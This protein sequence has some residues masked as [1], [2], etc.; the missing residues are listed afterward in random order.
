MN[1]NVQVSLEHT[2]ALQREETNIAREEVSRLMETKRVQKTTVILKTTNLVLVDDIEDENSTLVRAVD[3]L[4][5][6][7]IKTLL[8]NNPTNFTT[9]F[10]LVV[11]P[12]DCPTVADWDP[13]KATTWRYRVIGGNHGAR[14][15]TELYKAYGR[16][17]FNELQAWVYADLTRDEI[18]KLSIQHNIDQEYR[19]KMSNID[20]ARTIHKIFVA[21]GCAKTKETREACAQEVCLD[22]YIP[23]VPKTL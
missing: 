12:E 20:Q 19:K 9:P 23:G 14:A 3:R 22:G 2:T 5:V 11:V 6:E 18:Q 8:K 10:V 21:R 7:N 15:K 1:V 17:I 4:H 13:I 16:E